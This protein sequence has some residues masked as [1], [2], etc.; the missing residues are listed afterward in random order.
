MGIPIVPNLWR[1]V[2]GKHACEKLKSLSF[3]GDL[4]HR[5]IVVKG[6]G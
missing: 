5:Q 3:M 4:R 2:A 1:Y 6:S